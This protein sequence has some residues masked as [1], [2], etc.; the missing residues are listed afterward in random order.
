MSTPERDAPA[1]AASTRTRPEGA[2]AERVL[3]ELA[4]LAAALRRLEEH[5]AADVPGGL[6]E[7]DP[8]SGE[9]WDAGQVWAHLAEFGSYWL[10]EL[11]LIVDA[12]SKE[13]VPFGRTKADPHRIAEIERNRGRSVDSQLTVIRVDI[14]RYAHTL[15]SMTAEDWS[16]TGRHSTLG[17]MD[18]WTFL[19]H[20]VTGHYHE[21]AD[22]LDQI[23]DRPK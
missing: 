20:F 5:G 3:G 11:R 17:D 13:P 8:K 15:A 22:Q 4:D 12:A 10:P 14:A 21:H 9:Q 7:A 2:L 1:T 23:R 19:Q 6:T 18:L 16:R